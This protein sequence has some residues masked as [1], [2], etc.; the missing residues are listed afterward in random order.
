M[1]QRKLIIIR[2]K[3]TGGKTTTSH[4]L[5]RVL[6]GW[7]FVDIWKIKEMFEPLGLKDRTPIFKAS[8][9]AVLAIVKQVMR[10]IGSNIIVQESSLS[11]INKHLRKDIKKYNYKL[12]SFFL[13]VELEDAIK[14]DIQREKPTININKQNLSSA[15]WKKT[16]KGVPEKGDI[17]INTSKNNLKKVVNLILKEIHEKARKNP[18]AHLIRKCW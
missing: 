17:I 5:A 15:E 16:A 9:K 2:G 1:T 8:K 11:F 12:Y 13:D 4:A 3:V 10:D 7:I 18:N 6:P 14:R